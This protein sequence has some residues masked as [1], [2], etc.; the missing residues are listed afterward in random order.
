MKNSALFSR[1]EKAKVDFRPDKD[2]KSPFAQLRRLSVHLK[3]DH[4]TAEDITDCIDALDYYRE[5]VFM[6]TFHVGHTEFTDLDRTFP[7][8]IDWLLA[9]A[10]VESENFQS[11]RRSSN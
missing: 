6:K 5:Y 11:R 7:E 3:T 4:P 10:E 9:V 2:L 1:R 8:V